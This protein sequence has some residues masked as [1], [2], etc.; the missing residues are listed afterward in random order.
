M[1]HCTSGAGTCAKVQCKSDT[2]V[3]NRGFKINVRLVDEGNIS[4]S[5]LKV[6][7]F[8][9]CFF[10]FLSISSLSM[11]FLISPVLISLYVF[12]FLLSPS[13]FLSISSPSLHVSLSFFVL[14]C[15]FI[16]L[17][18]CLLLPLFISLSLSLLSLSLSLSVSVSL[19]LCSLSVSVSL[20]LCLCVSVFLLIQLMNVSLHN[21]RINTCSIRH[22]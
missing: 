16:C 3:T 12:N 13:V 11:C 18:L 15:V 4:L 1:V 10:L 14:G 5:C 8:S 6:Q 2:F 9:I 7:Q 21:W 19:C 22:E 20:C 17:P